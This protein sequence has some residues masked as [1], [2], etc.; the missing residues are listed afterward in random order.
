MNRFES[1]TDGTASH[2]TWLP[3]D[4]NQAAGYK[5][6]R[7]LMALLLVAFVAGCGNGGGGRDPILGGSV[8]VLQGLVSVKVT[9]ATASIPVS[10]TQQYTATGTYNDGS[11]KDVTASSTWTAVNLPLGGAAVATILPSGV[12][13]GL[14]FGQSTITATVVGLGGLG[15]KSNSATLTVTN[16]TVMS[17]LV[18]PATAS[19]AIGSK[20]N[21]KATA[22]M[23]D[24][25]T[26]DVTS[27]AVWTATNDALPLL[28]AV[29]SVLTGGLTPGVATGLNLGKSD[30]TAAYT[31]AGVIT[32]SP[33]KGAILTVNP[34]V[35]V[36]GPGPAG[37]VILPK[38]IAPYGLIAYDAITDASGS[39]VI[40]SH[41]YGDVALVEPASA[42]GTIASVVGKGFNDITGTPLKSTCVT[43]SDGTH[44]GVIDAANNG[45]LTG[46]Q[47]ANL[48]TEMKSVFDDLNQRAAPSTALTTPASVAA[49]PVNGG[50]G[51]FTPAFSSPDLS[52]YVFIPGIYTTNGTYGLSDTNGP[53]ILDAQG[54]SDAVFIIRSTA[55]G[56]SGLTSTNGSVV[57]Q[58]GAQAKNVF[59]VLD[60]LTLGA[61][62]FFQ[63]TVVSG[64]VIKLGLGTNVEGRMWTGAL[65]PT[66]AGSGAL[67]LDGTNVI[68]VPK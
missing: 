26:P 36:L 40:C 28:P 43:N 58:N 52:G 55:S 4:G 18:T 32:T 1:V 24:G 34:V 20:Q 2:S 63:G 68:T 57:L 16:A 59:W 62:T 27:G 15:G 8:S 42:G 61:G 60:N 64:H 35:L 65:V 33:A 11:S 50:G 12:A 47:L 23:S 5:P 51:T 14:N 7:W 56:A 17:I 6:L 54:N 45:T 19:I 25:T 37:G 39:I 29:A 38:E 30:I 66:L 10:G 21:Y 22:I 67:T 9:P 31:V 53:L 46:T 48:L 13:T 49:L 41:L 3:N 44:P